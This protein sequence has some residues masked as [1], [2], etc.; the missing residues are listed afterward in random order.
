MTDELRE[1][2]L[3]IAQRLFGWH[4]EVIW[5]EGDPYLF[6]PNVEESESRDFDHIVESYSTDIAAAWQVVERMRELGWTD[7]HLD[8]HWWFRNAA[9]PLAIRHSG[10]TATTAPEAIV[11][12]ALAA[13]ENAE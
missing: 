11:Q 5:I 12:A 8:N 13:L 2:D 7:G 1:L 4:G 10:Q 3:N 6:E 9:D